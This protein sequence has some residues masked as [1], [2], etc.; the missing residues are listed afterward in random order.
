MVVKFFKT[1][2]FDHHEWI[3]NSLCLSRSCHELNPKQ[4]TQNQTRTHPIIKWQVLEVVAKMKR[5]LI[6][7]AYW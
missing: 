4:Q 3:F 7:Y 1:L 2:F 5:T 6:S